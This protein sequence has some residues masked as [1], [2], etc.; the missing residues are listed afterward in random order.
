MQLS[1]AGGRKCA[2]WGCCRV[3]GLYGVMVGCRGGMLRVGGGAMG[4]AGAS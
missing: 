3:W 2:R 1:G 4:A